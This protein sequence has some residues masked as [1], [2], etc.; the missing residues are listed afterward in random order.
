MTIF[1]LL[2][3]WTSEPFKHLGWLWPKGVKWKNER[4]S[5]NRAYV[6]TTLEH[7]AN[8]ITHGIW[9]PPSVYAGTVLLHRSTSKLQYC[10]AVV[11]G[12]ALVL[13]FTVSTVFHSIFYCGHNQQLKDLLHRGDRAMIYV[14]IAASYFPWVMLRPL[15]QDSLAA[16]LWWLV[17]VLAAAGIL[18]QQMFHERYKTLETCFYI[19]LGAAPSLAVLAHIEHAEF[20]GIQE[21]TL[22]GAL[23]AIGVCFFKSDGVVPCA[24]AIWHMFVGAAATVHYYAILHHLYTAPSVE[25]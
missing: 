21:L 3:S 20:A 1:N 8:I 16:E 11:Y 23:Y 14:F 15:P 5:P 19:F 13:C 22:G 12:S 10:A 25:L 7:I 17:W 18:Y 4:A 2:P 24:H 9:I 6:P